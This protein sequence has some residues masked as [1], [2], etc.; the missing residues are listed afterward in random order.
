M[1]KIEINDPEQQAIEEIARLLK[2]AADSGQNLAEAGVGLC[3]D[4]WHRPWV[5]IALEQVAPVYGLS[6]QEL[7]DYFALLK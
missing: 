6:L 3:Q 5:E 7:S 1:K 4:N 2:N